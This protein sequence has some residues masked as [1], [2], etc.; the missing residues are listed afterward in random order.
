MQIKFILC[1]PALVAALLLG[2]AVSAFDYPRVV[3]FRKQNNPIVL[4]RIYMVLNLLFE[5]VTTQ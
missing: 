1:L 2:L 3:S 5:V 4:N